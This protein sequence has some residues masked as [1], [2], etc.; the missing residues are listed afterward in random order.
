MQ[1]HGVISWASQGP[2]GLTR[3]GS[4]RQAQQ[5]FGHLE[6]QDRDSRGLLMTIANLFMNG[7]KNVSIFRMGTPQFTK[8]S[9]N[10]A[11]YALRKAPDL[12]SISASGLTDPCL[13]L[14]LAHAIN[15]THWSTSS[16]SS[17]QTPVAFADLQT[18]DLNLASELSAAS[19]QTLVP[20]SPRILS[21]GPG[22]PC[23][24]PYPA[25]TLAAA[26]WLA[27]SRAEPLKGIHELSCQIEDDH[28]A[29]I[30]LGGAVL[31]R[32]KGRRP[33]LTLKLPK[34]LKSLTKRTPEP[35]GDPLL[36]DLKA[37]FNQG[38]TRQASRSTILRQL[39]ARLKRAEQSGEVRAT[40]R[41]P[42][43]LI[44]STDDQALQVWLNRPRRVL[45][46]KLNF[47]NVD[48]FRP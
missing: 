9:L 4:F 11:V 48:R 14:E 45:T 21:H 37:I 42:A 44:D 31:L 27:N 39:S 10:E 15:T 33:L 28:H 40:H 26:A 25:T 35:P 34:H 1:Q 46:V 17:R 16:L 2:P 6:S 18:L 38:Q 8:A 23:L 7:A 20:V 36:I 12:S 30:D 24:E 19:H 41:Q 32:A 47:N 5:R 29:L 3:L 43:F 22:R 13:L